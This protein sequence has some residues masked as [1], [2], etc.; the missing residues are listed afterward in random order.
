MKKF[1]YILNINRFLNESQAAAAQEPRIVKGFDEFSL[2]YKRPGT[3]LARQRDKKENMLVEIGDKINAKY[4]WL[5][6]GINRDNT[7]SDRKWASF[8]RVMYIYYSSDLVSRQ[9]EHSYN[10]ERYQVANNPDI[11]FADLGI[12]NPETD[13]VTLHNLKNNKYIES[14]TKDTFRLNVTKQLYDRFSMFMGENYSEEMK[15]HKFIVAYDDKDRDGENND[16]NFGI[17]ICD[18]DRVSGNKQVL[19]R[20][21]NKVAK[22]WIEFLRSL[23]LE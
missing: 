15:S 13:N 10:V 12:D 2:K 7:I 16:N 11:P 22:A 19:E 9:E 14:Y 20:L 5:V 21:A 3:I 17:I 8:D 4:N 1:K 6:C 23:I 18:W